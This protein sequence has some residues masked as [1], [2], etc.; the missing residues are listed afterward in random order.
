MPIQIGKGHDQ[1]TNHR[2]EQPYRLEQTTLVSLITGS[3]AHVMYVRT[4]VLVSRGMRGASCSKEKA[5][6]MEE[7]RG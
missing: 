7:I 5:R 6:M 4:Y 3:M 2:V 1:R